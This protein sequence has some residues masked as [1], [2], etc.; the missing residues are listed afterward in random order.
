MFASDMAADCCPDGKRAPHRTSQDQGLQLVEFLARDA[1][2]AQNAPQRADT[3]LPVLR[4]DHDADAELSLLDE[5]DV[6]PLWLY[7]TKPAASSLRLT[8]R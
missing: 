4:H 3:D 1:G 5:F 2:L 7:S 8:S 6:T